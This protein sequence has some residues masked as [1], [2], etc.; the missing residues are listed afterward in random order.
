MVGVRRSP[1]APWYSLG[2]KTPTIRPGHA[3]GPMAVSESG[4]LGPTFV[5]RSVGAFPMDAPASALLPDSPPIPR[6]RLI[7]RED[8]R[9]TARALLLNETVPLLILVG[10]GGVGKTRL[11]L[12]IAQ[13]VT[14]S[15]ADG[16][17]WVDLA[18]RCGSR[19][20]W[21]SSGSLARASGP[22]A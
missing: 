18:S 13:D 22:A 15:F 4:T 11:A 20:C 21:L 16:V 14:A 12:A 17:V 9:S 19:T 8:E 3:S 1:R 10:P 2:S 6:T 5:S 7:G